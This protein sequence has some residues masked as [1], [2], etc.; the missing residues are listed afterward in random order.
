MFHRQTTICR[1]GW[2]YL[3]IIVL[4]FGGAV[5]K[6]VNLLLILAGLLLG[7]LLLN[8][9]AVRSNLRGLRIER[10]LPTRLS[11]GETL[12][13]NL[14]LANT[15]PRLGCWAVAVEEQIQRETIESHEGNH[16]R[17]PIRFVWPRS[18]DPR[19]CRT[20]PG[21]SCDRGRRLPPAT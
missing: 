4:V 21:W 18:T 11:A 14:L 8:W 3:A 10:Q 15:R 6:E 2:Y 17:Q 20:L 16:R 1:E 12:S 9:R 13:V 5:L 19:G 7:P